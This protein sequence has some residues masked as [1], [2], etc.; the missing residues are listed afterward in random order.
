MDSY[1]EDDRVLASVLCMRSMV[2]SSRAVVAVSVWERGL[3]MHRATKVGERNGTRRFGP[4]DGGSIFLRN[5]WYPDTRRRACA[6]AQFV[7]GA[8]EANARSKWG[9]MRTVVTFMG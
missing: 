1:P 7:C 4:K 5:V 6:C 9:G 3:R 2:R 8:A